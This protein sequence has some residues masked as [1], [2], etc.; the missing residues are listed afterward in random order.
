MTQSSTNGSGRAPRSLAKSAATRRRVLDAAAHV[1]VNNGYAGTRLSD[2]A[3]EAGL[4]AGSLYYHFD[5]KEQLV[6]EVL[7]YGVQFT[8]AHVRVVIDQLPDSATA[9]Q[10]LSAAIGGF[11]EAIMELRYMSP[12]YLRSYRQL[13]EDM[14]ERLRPTRRSFGKFWEELVDAAIAS[15]E[16]RTDIDPYT[17][18]LF[19]VH[20][21]EQIPEWPDSAQRSAQEMSDMMRKLIFDGVAGPDTNESR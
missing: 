5:S 15:G 11:L 19:I 20:T 8:H 17:L 13:P 12:A 3:A 21:L 14:R 16:V 18:R 10:R 9:G 6:E 2:I 7:R 1:L 4:Q